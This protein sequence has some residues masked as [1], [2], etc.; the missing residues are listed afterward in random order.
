MK[1]V[2]RNKWFCKYC[3]KQKEEKDFYECNA[4][5]CR[6]CTRETSRARWQVVREVESA[7]N[8]AKRLNNRLTRVNEVYYVSEYVSAL[9]VNE[10]TLEIED[11]ICETFGC[12]KKLSMRERLFG[13][14]CIKHSK[15]EISYAECR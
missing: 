3:E 4:T 10:N 6:S 1:E 12:R 14:K 7:F 8:K 9:P 11:E 2:N 15:I 13:K 5:K